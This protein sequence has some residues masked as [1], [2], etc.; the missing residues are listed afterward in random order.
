MEVDVG[1][2]RNGGGQ[3]LQDGHAIRGAAG[4]KNTT[5]TK[6]KE[7]ELLKP[8]NNVRPSTEEH[9]FENHPEGKYDTPSSTALKVHPVACMAIEEARN[10]RYTGKTV[11]STE[12]SKQG[13]QHARGATSQAS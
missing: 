9:V 8:W 3:R 5:H 6:R 13:D 4:K 11:G 10:S 7:A 2:K 1:A 12:T